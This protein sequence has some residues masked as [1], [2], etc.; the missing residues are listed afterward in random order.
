MSRH[1]LQPISKRRRRLQGGQEILEFGLTAILLIP[2]FLGMV[3][4]GMSVIV[5]SQVNT[6]ARDLDNMYIHG[7]DF[8]TA[9]YQALAQTLTNGLGFQ[10]PAFPSGTNN[11]QSNTGTSGNGIIWITQVMWVGG[12]SS[13]NCQSVGATNC[14]NQNSFVYTQQIVF[15]NSNLTS[16]VNTSVGNAASNGATLS[17]SGIVTNPVTDATAALPSGAQTAMQGLWQTT[18]NGQTALVDG[19]IIYISEAYFQTPNLSIGAINNTGTYAR[20]F[21]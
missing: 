18:N 4:S 11:I 3:V 16:Q 7:A 17:T 14:T 5:S 10:Y 21:F 15:G 2:L 12:T 19:Q 6:I 9:P 13:P 20:Y 8:S 1:G